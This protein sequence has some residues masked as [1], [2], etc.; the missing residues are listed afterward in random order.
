MEFFKQ[1]NLDWMGKAKYF[2]ALSLAL[3]LIGAISVVSKGGLNYGIDFK[4]GT[5]V[6]VRFAGTPP[7]DQLRTGL[8]KEGLGESVIQ[9]ISDISNPNSNE[10]MIGLQQ[11]GQGSEA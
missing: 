2:F 4:G 10:V 7:V 9:P 6:D 1:V 8:V 3:L 5:L 11:Q